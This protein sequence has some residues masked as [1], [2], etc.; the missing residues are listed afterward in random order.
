VSREQS[1]RL[2]A[3]I[4]SALEDGIN[5]HGASID[6]VYRGGDF[7]NQFQVYQRAGELCDR[8]NTEIERIQVAQRSTHFCPSCQPAIEL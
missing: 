7:Q 5:R 3:A 6:W 1:E 2:W 8:C 4:R